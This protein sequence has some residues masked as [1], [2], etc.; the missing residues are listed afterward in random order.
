MFINLLW[1]R[2]LI[3]LVLLLGLSAVNRPGTVDQV[4]DLFAHPDD[5]ELYDLGC[6][7]DAIG[8]LSSPVSGPNLLVRG[9]DVSRRT[10]IEPTKYIELN[11]G[12]DTRKSVLV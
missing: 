6:F 5:Y 4:N 9:K 1:F 10:D 3:F 12:T 11:G 8:V 7:D 2:R